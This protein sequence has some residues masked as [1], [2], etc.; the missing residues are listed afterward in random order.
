MLV[1]QVQCLGGVAAKGHSPRNYTNKLL[2]LLLDEAKCHQLKIELSA[3]IE[4]L[5]DLRNLCYFLEGDGTDGSFLS[6][7][8]SGNLKKMPSTE[9]LIA[10]AFDW[11][12]N[13]KGFTPPDTT[14]GATQHQPR[15]TMALKSNNK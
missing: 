15:K 3:Y 6:M 4:A 7:Y 5:A 1:F 10:R 12:V 2:S 14:A 11:T 9:A 13:E 8:S